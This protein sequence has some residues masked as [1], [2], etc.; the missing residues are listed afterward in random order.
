METTSFVSMEM[1]FALFSLE[2][3]PTLRSRM[4][5]KAKFLVLHGGAADEARAGVALHVVGEDEHHKGRR[6][7][8]RYPA[9][10]RPAG[11]DDVHDVL[12]EP[13]RDK[14][15]AREQQHADDGDDERG[16]VPAEKA[17]LQL[18]PERPGARGQ[19]CAESGP[20]KVVDWMA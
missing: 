3:K 5:E 14:V 4:W 9:Y 17:A 8:E 7:G 15:H 10:A 19:S 1:N 12:H 16:H 20:V 2:T 18:P 6:K 11:G 13:G